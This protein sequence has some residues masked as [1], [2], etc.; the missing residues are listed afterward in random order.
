MSILIGGDFVPTTS[1]VELFEN[2]KIQELFGERLLEIFGQADIIIF[3]LEVPLA[4]AKSPIVKCGPILA[5]PPSTINTYKAIGTT[6]LS[7]ANNHIM[8]Q[9]EQGL[10]S[11]IKTINHE[12]IRY[13]GSG[14]NLEDASK[15]LF[16]T[17]K[18]TKYGLFACVEHE[19]SVATEDKPGANAFDPLYTLDQITETKEQCDF[20]IVLYHGGKEH[21]RYPSPGLQRVCR[22][23]IEKGADLVICQHSHCV[24]C[25]E[26]YKG[27]KIIYGQGNFLFDYRNEECWENGLL[28]RINDNNSIDYLP[29]VKTGNAVRLASEE[30]STRI[31]SDFMARSEE[32]LD[33]KAVEK[34]YRQFAET[35]VTPTMLTFLGKESILFRIANRVSRNRLREFRIR[36]RY[37]RSRGLLK[38]FNRICC[39]SW[40]ELTLKSLTTIIDK[41]N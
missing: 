8:D 34:H 31:L 17:C 15:P 23:L 24:G 25:E 27:G 13:V 35:M 5:A 39:E 2:G 30:E 11:T 7:L 26:N 21:Y 9:G 6:I 37:S 4:D 14:N 22:R 18:E 33:N 1:N 36:T 41:H 29:V 3:N 19:F 38:I 40:R 12:K 20:L 10:S 28:V 32:I 16:F